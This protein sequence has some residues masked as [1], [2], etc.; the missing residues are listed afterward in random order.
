MRNAV[1]DAF[2]RL[3][4]GPEAETRR[5]HRLQSDFATGT[6]GGVTYERWQYKISDGG[7]LWYFVDHTTSGGSASSV[8]IE[9]AEPGHPKAT[10]S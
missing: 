1:V 7:R 4:T 3:T 6:Y 9:R 2:D 8:L 5:Q 10:E